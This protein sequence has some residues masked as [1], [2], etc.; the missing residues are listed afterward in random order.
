MSAL[1][2]IAIEQGYIESE[3]SAISNFFR[4]IEDSKREITIKHLLMMSSGLKWSGN[5]AMLTAKN[6]VK[7]ILEQPV[8][9]E[10]GIEM[11]YSCGNSHLL[12]A[13]LQHT[14]KMDTVE[15]AKKTLFSPLGIRDFN[16]YQDAQGIA[17][18][19]FSL[20]LKLEDML[21]FGITYLN[22]GKWDGNQL[23]P[24]EWIKKSTDVQMTTNK[25]S[26]GYHWWI[27]NQDNEPKTYFAFGMGG[28]YIFV[29]EEKR[30]VTVFVSNIDGECSSP[31]EYLQK[32]I[33]S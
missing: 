1:Y 13:I 31:I 3:N 17:I 25:S 28:Q 22:D 27:L 21:K 11:K 30:I 2:G 23:I 20:T 16:W 24:V 32:Y 10:P 4:E 9:T 6:W 15:Y 8:E 5:E 26:Y 19:G 12:S 7:Y 14:T 18:G 33:L 29:N